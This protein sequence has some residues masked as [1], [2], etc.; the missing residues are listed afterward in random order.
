MTALTADLGRFLANIKFDQLPAGGLALVRDGF[1][2]PGGV[3]RVGVPKPVVD[4]F[5]RPLVESGPRREARA[6]LSSIYVAAPDAALL[7]GTAAHA[8]DYD[9]QSLTGHPSAVLVPAILAEG[10]MLGSNGQ[11]LVTAY[12]AGYGGWAEL[13][14]RGAHY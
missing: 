8:L 13:I 12:V 10:E 9:D 14:R 1:P 3:W 2:D 4:F 7:G 6:C 11:D 5:H